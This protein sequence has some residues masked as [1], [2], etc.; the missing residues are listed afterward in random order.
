[1]IMTKVPEWPRP[2]DWSYNFAMPIE[3]AAVRATTICPIITY[4][5]GLGAMSAYKSN[6]VN[7]SFVEA[8]T[9]HCFPTSRVNRIFCELKAQMSK[10]MLTDAVSEVRFATSIIHCA[11]DDGEAEDE[12]STLDL[13]EIIE[14]T[15]ET[16]DRQTYPLW[17]DIDLHDFKSN[18]GLDMPAETP[19]LDT[20]LEIE[21]TAFNLDD[22]Y[23]CLHYYTNGAKLRTIMTPLKWHTIAKQKTSA[24]ILHFSQQSNTKFLNPYTFLGLLIHV[25]QNIDK[26]Q[27][28]KPADTTVE[29]STLEFTFHTRYNEFNHEFNH[30]ML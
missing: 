9:D 16:T 12:V 6:P 21:A 20:D 28:G 14:L 10:I 13:N 7:A 18:A 8:A 3:S 29:T 25:P 19:G 5:E 4:D 2:H 1:M 27:Y 26:D 11:F 24:Q 30:S 15:G 22:Y 17:N 23:D